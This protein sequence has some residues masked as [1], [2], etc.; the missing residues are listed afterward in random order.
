MTEIQNISIPISSH[1]SLLT[2][3]HECLTYG[4]RMAT[5]NDGPNGFPYLLID[6]LEE[7]RDNLE[8]NHTKEASVHYNLRVIHQSSMSKFTLQIK[9]LLGDRPYPMY[10]STMELKN[11]IKPDS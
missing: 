2:F 8:V 10:P 4:A 6:H 3:N 1:T 7:W 11:A 5:T 9:F